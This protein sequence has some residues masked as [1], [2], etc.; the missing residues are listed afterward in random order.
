MMGSTNYR[1]H[2]RWAKLRVVIPFWE[3]EGKVCFLAPA[4]GTILSIFENPDLTSLS[5]VESIVVC[6]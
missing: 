1:R 2:A 6:V 3:G 4:F 5:E